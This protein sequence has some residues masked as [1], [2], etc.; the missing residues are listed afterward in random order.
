M[1]ELKLAPPKI[2]LYRRIV[3]LL[4]EDP[5]ITS[6]RFGHRRSLACAD[7]SSWKPVRSSHVMRVAATAETR[8]KW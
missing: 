5:D 8:W 7:A 3:A 2:I 1:M 4:G 6:P